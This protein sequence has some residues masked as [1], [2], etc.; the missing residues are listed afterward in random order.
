MCKPCIK[1][2]S[3]DEE[4]D[5]LIVALDLENDSVRLDTE[6]KRHYGGVEFSMTH[7]LDGDLIEILQD[8]KRRIGKEEAV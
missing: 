5:P 7:L 2:W 8:I 3:F 6:G 4:G 1:Y